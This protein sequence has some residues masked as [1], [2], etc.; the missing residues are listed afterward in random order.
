MQ[1]VKVTDRVIF[2]SQQMWQATWPNG[3]LNLTE[4]LILLMAIEDN[5]N[6]KIIDHCFRSSRGT[7]TTWKN[8]LKDTSCQYMFIFHMGPQFE[9]A[10][11]PGGSLEPD[12]LGFSVLPPPLMSC[13]TLSKLHKISRTQVGVLYVSKEMKHLILDMG[14]CKP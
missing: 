13:I 1:F 11:H 14:P 4:Y 6:L 7:Y 3:F 10:D 9:I 2:C 12:S 8:L 5:S